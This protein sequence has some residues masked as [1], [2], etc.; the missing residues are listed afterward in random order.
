MTPLL[1]ILIMLYLS[2]PKG[3]TL[4]YL[5]RWMQL[6]QIN[7]GILQSSMLCLMCQIQ[8]QLLQ[9]LVDLHTWGELLLI[10]IMSM[11]QGTLQRLLLTLSRLVLGDIW[12]RTNWVAP[13]S[14]HP[15][16]GLFQ[17][18]FPSKLS[19]ILPVQ[20]VII[21]NLRMKSFSNCWPTLLRKGESNI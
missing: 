9:S 4:Y 18:D 16:I 5:M 17:E 3:D 12:L 10:Q 13:S 8:Y 20:W 7:L 21:H 2:Y 14:V 6:H 1:V 19:L 15:K 11:G